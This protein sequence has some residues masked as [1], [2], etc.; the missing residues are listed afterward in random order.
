MASIIFFSSLW[1]F[2]LKEW[3]GASSAAL[4]RFWLGLAIL[5]AAAAPIGMDNLFDAV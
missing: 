4:A 3:K 5:L 1:G 2:L